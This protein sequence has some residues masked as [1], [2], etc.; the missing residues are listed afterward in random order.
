M[1]TEVEQFYSAVG[2]VVGVL[3]MWP[4][5]AFS[6]IFAMMKM[7]EWFVTVQF[8]IAVPPWWIVYGVT[9]MVT[10]ATFRTDKYNETKEMEERSIP[11]PLRLLCSA[12]V[13]WFLLGMAYLA[14]TY[15]PMIAG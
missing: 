8:S 9:L 12:F 4:G 15:G 11:L 3:I 1:S 13:S 10:L 2:K 7:W 14:K 5:A 6:Y